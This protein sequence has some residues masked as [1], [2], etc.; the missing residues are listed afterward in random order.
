M[1]APIYRDPVADGAADPTVIRK[2]GTNEW[3]MFYTNRQPAAEG[4]KH[5]WIHGSPIGVAVSTDDGASWHY[6]GTV[7]GLDDPADVLGGNTHWAPEVIWANGQYHMY[8]SYISGVPD[9]WRGVRRTITHF[10][11][12]DLETWTRAGPLTLSSPRVIDACVFHCPD[13]LWRLWYKDENAGSSTWVATSTDLF[14]WT[15][16][17]RVL[18]GSPHDAPHEGPNVFALGGWYWL[19]VDEWHGQGVYR[20]DD[21]IHWTKQGLIGGQPGSDPMDV[22]YARHADVVALKD[23]AAMYY[24]THPEWDERSQEAGPPDVAARKT[25][26]HHAGLRV[27]D[28]VLVFDREVPA[29]FAPLRG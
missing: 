17:G 25:A 3:W 6:R 11:S 16:E 14:D 18:A 9:D 7:K 23:H 13:G 2:E 12:P 19:I 27:V 24:F 1:S 20:S 10:T 4:P 5:T 8:L 28:D 26:V 15:V 22:R 29:G 21:C